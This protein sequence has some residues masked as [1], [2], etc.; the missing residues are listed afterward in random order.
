MISY[1]EL[2]LLV[3]AN[4]QPER[5]LVSV[6]ENRKLLFLYKYNEG[7]YYVCPTTSTESF[8]KEYNPY[9]NFNIDEDKFFEK[10]IKVVDPYL[11]HKGE[12][13]SYYDLMTAI[14]FNTQPYKVRLHIN[15]E[16]QDYIFDSEELFGAKRYQKAKEDD[17]TT[18]WETYLSQQITETKWFEKN[19]E[20]IECGNSLNRIIEG[21]C[22][23][24][25]FNIFLAEIIN[26][27]EDTDLNDNVKEISD[28]SISIEED[29]IHK[30][31]YPLLLKYF[32]PSLLE[33]K[34]RG[35][36]EGFEW[37]LTNNYYTIDDIEKMIKEIK[38]IMILLK[39]DYN[40]SKLDFISEGYKSDSAD[41]FINFYKRFI[42]YLQKMIIKGN[43]EGYNL[44]SFVG[45]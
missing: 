40:N 12:Y 8:Y 22:G 15:D 25:Y 37:Y 35:D 7:C 9:L 17:L 1:Y 29:T 43:E 16:E 5:V 24:S 26:I 4:K 13:V 10:N 3:Q 38:Q 41:E 14:T 18:Q 27:N 2:M 36:A 39:E 11:F 6:G 21:S 44:I 34:N 20:V 31:L 32:N 23:G 45:P 42:E 30:F 28:F 19:I 33:N